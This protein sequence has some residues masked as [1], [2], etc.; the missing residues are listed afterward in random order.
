MSN[1]NSELDL[2]R[3]D[4][5]EHVICRD[6]KCEKCGWNPVVAEARL[7]KIRSGHGNQHQ[8]ASD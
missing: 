8:E 6:R 7:E 4:H 1:N 2:W 5:N 3:C